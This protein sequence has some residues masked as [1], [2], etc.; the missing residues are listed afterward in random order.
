MGCSTFLPEAILVLHAAPAFQRPFDATEWALGKPSAGN[1]KKLPGSVEILDTL[2]PICRPARFCQYK[3]S[4]KN[5]EA[6]WRMGH[7]DNDNYSNRHLTFLDRHLMSLKWAYQLAKE[8]CYFWITAVVSKEKL[9]H[10]HFRPESYLLDK[11]QLQ[12][13]RSVLTSHSCLWSLLQ[14]D[15]DQFWAG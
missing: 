15:Y 5:S 2:R 10:M 6:C 12:D 7:Q 1:L 4:T 13:D 8:Y 14:K 9:F 11:R 3:F